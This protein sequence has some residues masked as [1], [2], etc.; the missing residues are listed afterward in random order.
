M[1]TI[2]LSVLRSLPFPLTTTIYADDTQLFSFHPLNFYSSILHIQ[3]A[4]QQIFSW[5]TAN[6]LTLNSSK[7][8]FLLIRLENLLVKTHNSSLDT[9][10]S[11]RNLGFIFDEHL[12]FSDQITSLSPSLSEGCYYSI[13][14]VNFAV[15]SLISIPQ[16]PPP[17][18]PLLFTPCLITLILSTT[19]SLSLILSPA[20][21]ELSCSYCR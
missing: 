11:A 18:L 17:L 8:E 15:F 9:S 10:H 20:D 13:T 1:Y 3:N 16:L 12:T 7:T 19:N 2:P 5:M 4:L 6:L 14:F 21:P